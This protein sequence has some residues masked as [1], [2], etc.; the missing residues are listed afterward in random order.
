DLH[1]GKTEVALEDLTRVLAQM[2]RPPAGRDAERLRHVRAARVGNRATDLRVLDGAPEVALL[3][4]RDVVV[5]LRR[6]HE[7]PRDAVR[8]RAAEDLLSLAGGDEPSNPVADG[9]ALAIVGHPRGLVLVLWVGQLAGD[10]LLL[11]PLDQLR[12]ALV[13]EG[14][15]NGDHVL[16]IPGR[17]LEVWLTAGGRVHPRLPVER[18][19]VVHPP[20]RPG[21]HTLP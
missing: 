9:G 17:Q 1:R 21:H 8:L 6:A 2:G 20:V 7:P 13:A 10:A 12:P 5:L 11:H 4:V 3:V 18:R 16:A 15:V 14:L 19:A